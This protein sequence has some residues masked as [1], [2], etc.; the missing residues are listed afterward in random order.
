MQKIFWLLVIIVGCFSL[1]EATT[2]EVDDSN[3]ESSEFWPPDCVPH[4]HPH[5]LPHDGDDGWVEY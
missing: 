3:P 1:I 5:P 2:F 4:P